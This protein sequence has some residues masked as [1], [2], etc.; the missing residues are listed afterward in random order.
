MRANRGPGENKCSRRRTLRLDFGLPELEGP[1]PNTGFAETGGKGAKSGQRD[2]FLSD[3]FVFE[4]EERSR[5]KKRKRIRGRGDKRQ[6]EGKREK[7]KFC[8]KIL[9]PSSRGY[10]A[11]RADSGRGYHFSGGDWLRGGWRMR[12]GSLLPLPTLTFLT[13]LLAALFARDRLCEA[14][15]GYELCLDGFVPLPFPPQFTRCLSYPIRIYLVITITRSST[16]LSDLQLQLSCRARNV[17]SNQIFLIRSP[18]FSIKS[19]RFHCYTE[20]SL[21][22]ESRI[23]FSLRTFLL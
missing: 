1:S 12:T 9:L 11:R 6:A 7:I 17:F 15:F 22:S 21:V 18:H 3:V 23:F 8:P 14:L 19:N 13:S 10:G 16:I 20:M 2:I 4:D 5:Q